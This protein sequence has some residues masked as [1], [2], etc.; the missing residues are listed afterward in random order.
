MINKR[1]LWFLTLFSLILVLSVYYITMPSELLMTAN[2]PNKEEKT[3]TV[4]KQEEPKTEEKENTEL[5]ALRV[6]A[7]EQMLD[8]MTNL[9]AILTNNNKTT[10]EKNAALEQM[11]KLNKNR[12]LEEKIEKKL[13]ETFDL[14]TFVKITDS[15]VSVVVDSTK[16]DKTLANNI[17]RQV[18]EEFENHVSISVKFQK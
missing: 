7:E 2:N 17:M 11:Q 6:E 13:K 14:K 12:G 16:H 4:S 10:E 5:V 18:Q 9:K 3:K 8:E 1:N 15:D